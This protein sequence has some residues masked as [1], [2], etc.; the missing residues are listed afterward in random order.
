M[1]VSISLLLLPFA[2]AASYCPSRAATTQEQVAIFR[3]FIHKFYINRDVPTAFGDHFDRNVI[4]HNP[5]SQSGWNET[6]IAGLAGFVATT[7]FTILNSGFSDN[8][9]YVH[10]REER[11]GALPT[12]VVDVL[13]FNGSCIVEHWDVAQ[14]S[15][16]F[17]CEYVLCERALEMDCFLKYVESNLDQYLRI[18]LLWR[19]SQYFEL[20]LY[21]ATDS[22][23]KLKGETYRLSES[24][25]N[26][27]EQI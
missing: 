10:F 3:E 5:G 16:M 12:A 21:Q 17:L 25:R 20:L 27:V 2:S 18:I 23:V 8:R 1:K 7:N 9:G 15:R 24:S 6:S 14:V 26:V 4:E 13:R 19:L 11:D 22:M